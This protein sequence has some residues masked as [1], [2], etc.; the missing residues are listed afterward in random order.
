M[1]LMWIL[2][3]LLSSSLSFW[4]PLNL[5]KPKWC[6]LLYIS[7][8][9]Y[10]NSLDLPVLLED[11]SHVYLTECH[12]ELW[13]V[14]SWYIRFV[15][16]CVASIVPTSIITVPPLIPSFSPILLVLISLGVSP[17]L[18]NSPSL[19]QS[20]VTHL[21]QGS[22]NIYNPIPKTNSPRDKISYMI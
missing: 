2:S 18:T 4:A 15:C 17:Y 19:S 3:N 20:F 22:P 14:K 10:V 13:E 7:P 1:F 12:W 8:L 6:P 11:F 9:G 21:C 5:T 16:P